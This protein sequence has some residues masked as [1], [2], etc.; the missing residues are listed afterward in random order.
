[1][2]SLAGVPSRTS[3]PGVPTMSAFV[4]K[5]M[6]GPLGRD[7]L[8]EVDVGTTQMPTRTAT[9]AMPVMDARRIGTLPSEA[10]RSILGDPEVWMREE[11]RLLTEPRVTA[12]CEVVAWC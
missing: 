6:V 9:N 1:M 3:S 12:R 7:G 2:T 11:E 8:A 5:Q 10:E 4:P